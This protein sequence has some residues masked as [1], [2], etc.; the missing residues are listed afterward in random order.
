MV[1]GHRVGP[2]GNRS[3]GSPMFALVTDSEVCA[4]ARRL[5]QDRQHKL[6]K[7]SNQ[8]SAINNH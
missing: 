4:S 3:D 8:K 6:A 2:D 7:I 5:I 1:S